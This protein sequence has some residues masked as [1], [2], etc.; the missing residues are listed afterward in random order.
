MRDESSTANTSCSSRPS[1]PVVLT[2]PPMKPEQQKLLVQLLKGPKTEGQLRAN[3]KDL[4]ALLDADPSLVATEPVPVGRKAKPRF[5]LTAVGK[6]EA[7]AIVHAPKPGKPEVPARPTTKDLY[8]LVLSVRDELRAALA[9]PAA[10]PERHLP[11]DFDETLRRTLQELN[12]RGQ[13][14]G[15]VPLPELRRA[16]APLGVGRDAL[17]RALLERQDAR[18]LDLKTANDPSLAPDAA[19]G[20]ALPGRGLLYYVVVR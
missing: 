4:Q 12:A 20:I 3:A 6:R 10:P 16:L 1:A 7:E 2:S 5:S 14:G 8:L 15:L 9:R 18:S 13:H 11:A 17:D 19:D